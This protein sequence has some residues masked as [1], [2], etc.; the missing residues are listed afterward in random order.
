MLAS[1]FSPLFQLLESSVIISA[2]LIDIDLF[3]WQHYSGVTKRCSRSL[4]FLW[5]FYTFQ[6]ERILKISPS[7][8]RSGRMCFCQSEFVLALT[9]IKMKAS[10]SSLEY[11]K[12]KYIIRNSL[13]LCWNEVL[14]SL[15]QCILNKLIEIINQ[16]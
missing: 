14:T 15:T 3:L 9:F 13:K 1:T 11:S 2:A 10:S 7:K 12:K 8:K 5:W 6:M 4:K 16:S